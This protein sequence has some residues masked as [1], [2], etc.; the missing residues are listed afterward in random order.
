[1]FSTFVALAFFF[2][3]SGSSLIGSYYNRFRRPITTFSVAHG[4]H[5]WLRATPI[6]LI[7]NH[8]LVRVI[9]NSILH[10]LNFLEHR[11]LIMKLI[12]YDLGSSGLQAIG[13]KIAQL[14]FVR[15]LHRI[16]K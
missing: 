1:V 16:Q 4:Q 10:F 5:I 9:I 15:Q 7:F 6:L 2:I 11:N 3:N 12:S 8:N 14:L 13:H